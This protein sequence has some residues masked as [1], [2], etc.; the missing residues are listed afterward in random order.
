MKR[1]TKVKI[2]EYVFSIEILWSGFHGL[3]D[4][5]D[6]TALACSDGAK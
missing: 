5:F 2:R 4:G 1:K 3:L 6:F